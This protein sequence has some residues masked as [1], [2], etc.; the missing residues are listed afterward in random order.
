MIFHDF[1]LDA[2]FPNRHLYLCNYVDD[3]TLRTPSNLGSYRLT[4][5]CYSAYAS[6]GL[7]STPSTS[8]T[9]QRRLVKYLM[10]ESTVSAGLWSAPQGRALWS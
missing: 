9:H 5:Y 10:L 6:L 8:Y 1:C 2:E 4:N 7:L 3:L